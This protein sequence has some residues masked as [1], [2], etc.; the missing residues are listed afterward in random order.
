[1]RPSSATIY[2]GTALT[3]LLLTAC[4]TV[5]A[6]PPPAPTVPY[7]VMSR[8]ETLE[9][10][11]ATQRVQIG[12]LISQNYGLSQDLARLRSDLCRMAVFVEKVEVRKDPSN[13]RNHIVARDG[14]IRRP[15]EVCPP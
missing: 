4:T 8:I 15:N 2:V 5:S 9:R 1:M 14:A 6:E 10:E 3:A 12:Q 11:N 7:Y 13:G